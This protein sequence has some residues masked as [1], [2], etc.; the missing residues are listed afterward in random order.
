VG[1]TDPAGDEHPV[2]ALDDAR[3]VERDDLL[4]AAERSVVAQAL[5]EPASVRFAAEHI[6]GLDFRD[7]RYGQVFNLVHGLVASGAPTDRLS[8]E[9]EIE[10]RAQ[11]RT[12]GP[13]WPTPEQVDALTGSVTDKAIADHARIVREHSLRRQAVTIAN[14]MLHEARTAPDA[15]GLASLGSTLFVQMR[16]EAA[17]TAPVESSSLAGILSAPVVYR[18]IVPGL[19]E[20]GD[21]LILTG[22]E[23]KG[24]SFLIRQLLLMVAGGLHPWTAEAIPPVDTMAVDVENSPAQWQRKSGVLVERVATWGSRNPAEHVQVHFPRTLDLTKDRDLGWVHRLIDDHDPKILAIG[25]I[26]RL[27]GQG[28]EKDEHAM[29]LL[30]ALDTIRARGVA[31]LIEAHAGHGKN[32]KG[33]REM[34]PRGSSALMGW[35]EFGLGLVADRKDETL[36]TLRRW[37]GD[38]DDREWPTQIRRHVLGSRVPAPTWPWVPHRVEGT[39]GQ[40]TLGGAG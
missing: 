6:T 27:S 16:D 24:K 31:L 18:W 7:A 12:K 33:E 17:A 38:R 10:R 1:L 30:R 36:A 11:A 2:T 19:L 23:G 15:A 22:E 4:A 13:A 5:A 32:A 35:P 34:R 8:V 3:I 20:E 39:I 28:V 14:R 21:R 26:Y 29:P 9:A 40:Q 37:R 25:P